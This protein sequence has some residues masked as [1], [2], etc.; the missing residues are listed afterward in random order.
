MLSLSTLCK[1]NINSALIFEKLCLDFL[2][3]TIQSHYERAGIKHKKT[4][5]R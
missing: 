3:I 1:L 5:L 2:K 4:I